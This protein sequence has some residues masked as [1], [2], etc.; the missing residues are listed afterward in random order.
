MLQYLMT[1][2]RGCYSTEN[3]KIH[4]KDMVMNYIP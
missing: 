2:Y 3:K 4:H 1:I